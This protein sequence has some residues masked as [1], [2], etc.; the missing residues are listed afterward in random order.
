MTDG[1]IIQLEIIE[2][3]NKNYITKVTGLYTISSH[4]TET[5][6]RNG[7]IRKCFLNSSKTEYNP[8]KFIPN[9]KTM[10]IT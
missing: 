4:K 1:G 8:Y 9:Q 6:F 5:G 3:K 7:H 2:S 10:V